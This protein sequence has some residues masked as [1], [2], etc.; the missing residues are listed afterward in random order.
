MPKIIKKRVE[1]KSRSE[2]NI[3]ETV[4]DIRQRLKEKQRTMVYFVVTFLFAVSAI[5][6]L[7]VYIRTNTSRALELEA[8]GQKLFYSLSRAESAAPSESYRKALEIFKKSYETKKRPLVLL[9]IAN[10]YY[11]IGNYDETIKTL[12]ELNSKGSDQNLLS[13]SYYKMAAA[14][15]KKGD[16]DN[17]LK[18]YDNIASLKGGALQDVALL[19]SGKI[20]DAMGKSDEAKKKYKELTDRFSKSLAVNESSGKSEAEGKK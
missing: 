6:A 18:A 2:G 8:E 10:C 17:A 4:I 20:L 1:G 9:H 7:T 14:Y 5:V 3:V 15:T 19:E 13:L 11:A 16:M 12:T